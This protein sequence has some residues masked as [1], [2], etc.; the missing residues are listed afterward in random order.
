MKKDLKLA[1]ETIKLI[2]TL[3]RGRFRPKSPILQFCQGETSLDHVKKKFLKNAWNNQFLD[4]SI[5]QI[6]GNTSKVQNLD[7]FK[8]IYSTTTFT[9][10]TPLFPEKILNMNRFKLKAGAIPGPPSLYIMQN[11]IGYPIDY[12]GPTKYLF[13]AF[14]TSMNFR[15][16]FEASHGKQRTLSHLL[17]QMLQHKIQVSL[18]RIPI[19]KYCD[20]SCLEHLITGT[21]QVV[22]GLT[23]P[24]EPE[25]WKA[26]IIFAYMLIASFLYSSQLHAVLTSVKLQSKSNSKLTTLADLDKSGLVL[27][28]DPV[29]IPWMERH[30]QD[31]KI[32]NEAM[33]RFSSTE[34]CVLHIIAEKN[35]SCL[36]SNTAADFF[37][38]RFKD[39]D[40]KSL[41]N[42][43]KEPFV[44]STQGFYLEPGSP[45]AERFNS[46]LLRLMAFGVFKKWN[47]NFV[48]ITSFSRKS[49]EILKDLVIGDNQLLPVLVTILLVGYLTSINVFLIEIAVVKMKKS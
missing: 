30:V 13:K 39:K 27:I 23:V 49:K 42:I 19:K 11:E 38:L 15:L 34:E 8:R 16:T 1:Q 37:K 5:L 46:I 14:A 41:I 31:L 22:L 47:T 2:N 26:R 18:N 20:N 35:V 36:M 45:Y 33:F 32:V 28:T 43:L 7:P 4:I 3:L 40:G 17:H 6:V 24:Q 21:M 12:S 29:A 44:V 25:N 48:P 10:S 9:S